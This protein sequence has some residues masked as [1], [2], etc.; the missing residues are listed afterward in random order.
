MVATL[1]SEEICLPVTEDEIS[2]TTKKKVNDKIIKP[3]LQAAKDKNHMITSIPQP[4]TLTEDIFRLNYPTKDA[5]G[6]TQ[7]ASFTIKPKDKATRTIIFQNKPDSIPAPSAVE[8]TRVSQNLLMDDHTITILKK[9]KEM[10]NNDRVSRAWV[11]KGAIRYPL[12]ASPDVI[13]KCPGAFA[14][15]SEIIK[16]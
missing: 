15:L 9:I 16:S 3:V 10:R 6:R 5:Q 14:S 11:T 1:E 7:T 4:N 2:A 12:V 8:V 13:R